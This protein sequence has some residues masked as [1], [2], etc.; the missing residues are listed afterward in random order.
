M[1]RLRLLVRSSVNPG[2]I[3][4]GD[5]YEVISDTESLLVNLG[6]SNSFGEAV[7]GLKLMSCPALDGCSDYRIELVTA[8]TTIQ[9]KVSLSSYSPPYAVFSIVE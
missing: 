6:K 8:T 4:L 3:N 7:I 5:R 2:G 1:S 9:R